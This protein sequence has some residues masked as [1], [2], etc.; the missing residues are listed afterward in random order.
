MAV[1]QEAPAAARPE[2]DRAGARERPTRNWRRIRSAALSYA[3]LTVFAVFTVFPFVWMLLT[4]FKSRGNI[5]VLPPTIIPDSLFQPGM[6]DAYREVLTKHDFGRYLLNSAFVAS[7][8][9]LGQVIT[10]SLAGFASAKMEFR[11]A[12]LMFG[13][14]VLSLMVPIEVTIIEEFFIVFRLGWLNTIS[15]SSFRPSSSARSGRS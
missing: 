4:T 15:R 13:L 14:L 12:K 10:A 7:M 8:A 6:F 5:F 11:G 1:G 2:R 3:L 9:G